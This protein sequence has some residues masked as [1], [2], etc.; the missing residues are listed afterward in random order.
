MDPARLSRSPIA[1]GCGIGEG[2]G[3]IGRRTADLIS[4]LERD[5]HH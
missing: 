3:N 5:G 1:H 2:L 4:E